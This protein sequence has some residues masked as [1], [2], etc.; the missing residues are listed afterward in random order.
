MP[1]GRCLT[2]CLSLTVRQLL[3]HQLALTCQAA[4]GPS[5]QTAP[6]SLCR[7]EMPQALV[8]AS[9]PAQR[10]GPRGRNPQLLLTGAGLSC[11]PRRAAV[12]P[13]AVPPQEREPKSY[14]HPAGRLLSGLSVAPLFPPR[15][16]LTTTAW[17]RH[18]ATSSSPSS[19][20]SLVTR[21][22]CGCYSGERGALCVPGAM[23]E[24]QEPGS[25]FLPHSGGGQVP[26]LSGHP[27]WSCDT[28]ASYCRT[29]C[30]TYHDVIPISCLTEFPNVVQMAKAGTSAGP[31]QLWC[32]GLP[33]AEPVP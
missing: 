9:H 14:V 5:Q 29:K 13:V 32:P 31:F 19:T 7:L 30:R 8:G 10:W 20:M 23:P 16:T 4:Q 26:G 11:E 17:T 3:G 22:T 21:S 2:C 6:P 27:A 24:P 1:G 25:C 33:W 28:L 15:S 12:T 18:W